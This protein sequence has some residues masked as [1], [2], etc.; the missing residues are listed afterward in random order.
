VSQGEM[1]ASDR[2]SPAIAVARRAR[3][4]LTPVGGRRG[5]AAMPADVRRV[6]LVV[7][8]SRG[9]ST[10]L[11]LLLRLTG[12][13]CFLDGEH[14]QLYRLFGLNETG[15]GDWHDGLVDPAHADVDGFVRAVLDDL[16]VGDGLDTR[17]DEFAHTV[18]RRLFLQWHHML[19]APE[20]VL[21][22]VRA[23]T[24]QAARSN[25]VVT[26]DDVIFHTVA[27][28]S[29]AS[30][31]VNPWNYDV[32]PA[33]IRAV[34]PTLPR[35]AAP[36][37]DSIIEIPPFLVPAAHLP[38]TAK[39]VRA[40]PV[41]LK[42][43]VDAY[44]IGLMREL[45][46][47]AE[48]TVVH[49]VR[50]P[51]AAVNGLMDG[52]LHRGFFSH[53]LDDSCRLRIDGYSHLPWGG[54][55]WNFD[56]PPRWTEVVERPLPEVCA[57]QWCAAHDAILA[58]T[59]VADRYLRL[60]AEDLMA[61]GARRHGAIGQVIEELGLAAPSAATGA[62]RVVAMTERPR[63][64]RWRARAALLRPALESPAVQAMVERL[65]YQSRSGW[66]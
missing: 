30:V 3:D 34:F 8:S 37:V 4:E 15:P 26:P 33:R 7:S 51:A 50:N 41:L 46:P 11:H 32:D 47:A 64:G 58:S 5:D 28:L 56:L 55:W 60:R 43:S 63:P 40:R 29:R 2:T 62:E 27:A 23:A 35:P 24:V 20:T 59:T 65:G 21:E 6:V 39:D 1:I 66:I 44:R 25:D 61:G 48:L 10:L 31:P 17:S 45:F 19:P 36:P 22:F 54:R 16:V 57:F 9:G 49:L 13:F 18:A 14:L 52:W 42:A 12:S 53:D 38:A